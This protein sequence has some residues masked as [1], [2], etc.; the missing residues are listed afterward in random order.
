M[1]TVLR[2]GKWGPASRS[3]AQASRGHRRQK[4]ARYHSSEGGK[5]SAAEIDF[6]PSFKRIAMWLCLIVY[7]YPSVSF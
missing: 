7:D 2:G 5:F 4:G 6:F 1:A 3:S